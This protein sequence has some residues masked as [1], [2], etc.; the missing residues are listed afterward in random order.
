MPLPI[1]SSITLGSAMV[2]VLNTRPAVVPIRMNSP[3]TVT[4]IHI[5][6]RTSG[7]ELRPAAS[8]RSSGT[9]TK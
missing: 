9:I 3:N 7:A 4:I 1:R 6:S 2:M 5:A 8:L